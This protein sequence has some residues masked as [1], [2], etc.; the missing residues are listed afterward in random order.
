MR[1]FSNAFH[2]S[3]QY[4][5][6]SAFPEHEW[7]FTGNW[8]DNRPQL[9]N[10]VLDR[11][12]DLSTYDFLLAHSPMEYISL[13]DRLDERGMDRA[14]LVYITHWGRQP[15]QWIHVYDGVSFESFLRDVSKSPIVCV[16]HYMV[17][18]FEF[19]S[20]IAVEV[21]PHFIPSELFDVVAWQEGG[22]DYVNVV[23]S[24][25][26]PERGV[27]A[28]FWDA[29][30]VEKKLYGA[31][32]RLEDGGSLATVDEFKSAMSGAR[33]FL[34]T[35]DAVATSFAPL[36][37]MALGC[38]LI[39]PDNLDW[40]IEFER[41]REILLYRPGDASSCLDQIARF[42][43]NK[44]FR[45][46]LSEMGRD[47]VFS[48]FR[49]D[50]FRERWERIFHAGVNAGYQASSDSG[51]SFRRGAGVV[52]REDG[53]NFDLI[54][55]IRLKHADIRVVHPRRDDVSVR[56]ALRNEANSI[57]LLNGLHELVSL[58][59]LPQS[60]VVIAND[61]GSTTQVISQA[62]RGAKTNVL[63]ADLYFESRTHRF[64]EATFGDNY[65][66]DIGFFEIAGVDAA[67][68][69]VVGDGNVGL[70][71]LSNAVVVINYDG[72]E[73]AVVGT[74]LDSGAAPDEFILNCLPHVSWAAGCHVEIMVE[75]LVQNGYSIDY[76]SIPSLTNLV[77]EIAEGDSI[78]KLHRYI[79]RAK[80]P[81]I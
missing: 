69:S 72:F 77:G 62:R 48:R 52:A 58:Q 61:F 80:R 43:S 56:Q 76:L 68:M 23:N 45:H 81:A 41:D 59:G 54:T 60:A 6:A 16:S 15:S 13:A 3:Y 11:A 1:I 10:V 32:N 73:P 25:Y 70:E 63:S 67:G 7:T 4:N 79:L 34:W 14:R 49:K 20:D 35:A 65:K 71:L 37:A 8:S 26:A 47:A 31:G 55:E 42:E 12:D 50:L 33:A 27:G 5:L 19:Y 22:S 18:Q 57:D 78:P 64:N 44:G 51:F 30:P 21:I 40:R 29:L 38:P 75:R 17:S 74:I 36:E 53:P 24:F 39:A 66:P 28:E 46:S 9:P 2:T